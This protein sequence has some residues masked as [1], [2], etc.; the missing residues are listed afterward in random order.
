MNIAFFSD[1]LE[2]E[3]VKEIKLWSSDI[4]EKPSPYFNN[5]PPCPY[6]RNAWVDDK[7][8]IL[9][10]HEENYQT[11]YSC[12][13]QWDDKH[14]IAIIA[15]LGNTKNSEDFHEYLDGLNNCISEG[16]FID[17]DIWLMG[18]HPDDEPSEFVQDVEFAPLVETPYAMIFVQRLS[19]LQQAADKLDKKGYYDTYDAE[20]NTRDIY[21]LRETLYRR[22]KDGDETQKA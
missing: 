5:L 20:Y 9:F 16:M 17:K 12:M 1:P 4:L 21:E 15:D 14:D 3:I 10:I 11:L 8:A 19:K 18:F 22:L 6:A 7:V 2:A 13:S